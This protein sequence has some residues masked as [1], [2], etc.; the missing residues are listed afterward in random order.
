MSHFPAEAHRF[1]A[2][3]KI[4]IVSKILK[5]AALVGVLAFAGCSN[6]AD[7]AT[8]LH[9]GDL[10]QV[11]DDDAKMN[12]ALAKGKASLP[13]FV[14]ALKENQPSRRKFA[15]YARFVEN[16]KVEFLWIEPV[17]MEG[18]DFRGTVAN[19]P[20]MLTKVKLGESILV[21]AAD[22]SD[23]MYVEDG[24]LVGGYSSRALR[25]SLSETERAEFDKSM[26]YS[27]D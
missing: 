16:E 9:D 7:N 10:F 18:A 8:K 4:T 23:W 2:C 6:R 11:A 12:A 20:E 15:V 3:D 19:E 24:K 27:F 22:V 14:A 26:P 5:I 17:A 13:Q 25:D 1:I 21:P